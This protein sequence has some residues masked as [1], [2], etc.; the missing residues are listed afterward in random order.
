MLPKEYIASLENAS[1]DDIRLKPMPPTSAERSHLN[2]GS[3]AR[4]NS[5]I[6]TPTTGLY[7]GE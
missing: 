7:T 3:D 5:G 2:L 6:L 1:N 4:P